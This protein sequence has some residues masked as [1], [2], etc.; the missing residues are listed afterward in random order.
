MLI[1]AKCGARYYFKKNREHI[2]ILLNQIYNL[3]MQ[4]ILKQLK[5]SLNHVRDATIILPTIFIF[6]T[7]KRNLFM[8]KI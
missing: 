5:I 6:T 8:D 3:R 2:S 7:S 1:N 4:G